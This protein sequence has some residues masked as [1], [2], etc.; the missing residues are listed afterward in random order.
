MFF[1]IIIFL[2]L[3][4]VFFWWENNAIYT[5]RIPFYSKTLPL[6][7]DG[8]TVV[9]LSDIHGKVFGKEHCRLIPKIAAAKPDIIV[10]TGDL[11]DKRHTDISAAFELVQLIKPLAPVY[12]VCGNHEARM[13]DYP[14]FAATLEQI[15]IKV[16]CNNALVLKKSGACIDLM[17]IEDPVFWQEPCTRYSQTTADKISDAITKVKK[18]CLTPFQLALF[19][20]PDYFAVFAKHTVDLVLCGHAHG[21]QFRLPFIGGL[22][23]PSQGLF[24]KYTAGLYRQGFSQMIVSRGLGPS[25]IPLRLFNRPD[26]VIITLNTQK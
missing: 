7:F 12:Y 4:A 13:A 19:H 9:Q 23:A 22:C 18:T 10:I 20:Q 2:V 15:G 5:T 26:L 21:G 6:G 16:L 25:I 1:Y 3:L 17:G 11:A 14:A 24:P 8:F